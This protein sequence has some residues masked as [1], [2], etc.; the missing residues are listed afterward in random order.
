MAFFQSLLGPDLPN[1]AASSVQ[2]VLDCIPQLVTSEDNANLL[3]PVTLEEVKEA[4]FLL[5]GD[6]CPGPDGFTWKFFQKCWSIIF[7]DLMSAVE[8]FFFAGVPVPRSV[9]S[10]SII[11]LPKKETPTSFADFRPISLCNF[12]NKVYTRILCLRI[13][14]LLSKLISEEQ[15]CQGP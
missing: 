13:Q 5:N 15:V 6:S 8:D 2:T 7:T 4:V 11:L 14:P 9:A 12:I 10:T 3:R 1:V